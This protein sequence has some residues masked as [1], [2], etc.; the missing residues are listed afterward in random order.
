MKQS[1]VI[2]S[3]KCT[4]CGEKPVAGV[5]DFVK[6]G[7]SASLCPDHLKKFCE[8]TIKNMEEIKNG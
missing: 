3:K 8:S 2:L 6:G 4:I 1:K 7:S 5:I